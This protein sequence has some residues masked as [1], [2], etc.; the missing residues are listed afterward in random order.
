LDILLSL[1]AKYD[2]LQGTV[3]ADFKTGGRPQYTAGGLLPG[4]LLLLLLSTEQLAK[5]KNTSGFTV[6]YLWLN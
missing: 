4:L 3:A 6:F 2:R 5:L 1:E